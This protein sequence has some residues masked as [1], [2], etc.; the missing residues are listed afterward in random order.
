[1]KLKE[2]ADLRGLDVRMRPVLIAAEKVWNDYGQELVVTAGLDGAHSA[3]SLHYYGL[4]LDFR[5]NYFDNETVLKV[6]RD[7]KEDLPK[8]FDVILEKTHIHVEYDI[9]KDN[10]LFS[11][12]LRLLGSHQ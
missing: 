12:L 5:I 8:P 4:A 7:L 11:S 2:G 3:G 9:M 1:M 10:S 6:V